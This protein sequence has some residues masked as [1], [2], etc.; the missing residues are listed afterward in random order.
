MGLR[1]LFKDTQNYKAET[2]ALLYMALTT[3][4]AEKSEKRFQE[5]PLQ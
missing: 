4:L 5:R 1:C 3:K 2:L